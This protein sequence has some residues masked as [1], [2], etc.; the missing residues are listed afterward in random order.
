MYVCVY[1]YMH[2]CIWQG[3]H[4]HAADGCGHQRGLLNTG[5][6]CINIYMYA[7]ACMYVC[8]YICTCIHAY[9]KG[10]IRTLQ[11]DVATNEGY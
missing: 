1:M 3:A 10:R 6:I 7:Y 2:T 5:Y 9:G 11:M 8:V 4:P